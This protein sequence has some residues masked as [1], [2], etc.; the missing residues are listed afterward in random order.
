MATPY[1]LQDAIVRELQELFKDFELK[2]LDGDQAKLNIYPQ[3][4]PAKSS[5]DDLEHFPYIIVRILDGGTLSEEDAAT[6]TIGLYIGIFDEDTNH[7][8][9]KDVLNILSR[10]E[11]HFLAKRIIDDR[12]VISL[13]F[14][15][16]VY[17]E[18]IYPYYF[19]GAQTKWSLPAIKQEVVL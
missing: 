9:Y 13:P 3:F 7:Q 8:G 19:G 10:M 18:D 11:Q 5:E 1:L 6:C 12:Y 4:L 16:S 14:D 15:W 17:D 2:G